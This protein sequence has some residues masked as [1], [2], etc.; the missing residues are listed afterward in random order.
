MPNVGP[1][2]ELRALA[3]LVAEGQGNA[4]GANV[5]AAN[6]HPKSRGL[7]PCVCTSN[8]L[9][10]GNARAAGLHSEHSHSR[11][12]LPV[13]LQWLLPFEWYRTNIECGVWQRCS[14]RPSNGRWLVDVGFVDAVDMDLVLH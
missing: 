14:K 1:C 9:A 4:T 8:Y 7:N 5:V 11:M 10:N 3:L 12:R 13:V 6:H 2:G